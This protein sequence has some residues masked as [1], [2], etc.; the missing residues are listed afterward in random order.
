MNSEIFELGIETLVEAVERMADASAHDLLHHIRE[1]VLTF[2][3]NNCP[4][5]DMTM[6]TRKIQ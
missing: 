2:T 3:N 6:F 1:D 4:Y 5:D